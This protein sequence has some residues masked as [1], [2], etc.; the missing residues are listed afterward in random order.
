M[1]TEHVAFM[2]IERGGRQECAN[3]DSDAGTDVRVRVGTNA[4]ALPRDS[5]EGA[6]SSGLRR[7][8]APDFRRLMTLRAGLFP[9]VLGQLGPPSVL[10][11]F[12]RSGPSGCCRC[13]GG[14]TPAATRWYAPA[15]TPKTRPADVLTGTGRGRWENP[16]PDP[17]RRPMWAGAPA[18]DG[19]YAGRMYESKPWRRPRFRPV[20]LLQVIS[21]PPRTSPRRTVLRQAAPDADTSNADLQRARRSEASYRHTYAPDAEVSDRIGRWSGLDEWSTHEREAIELGVRATIIVP[22]ARRQPRPH[23]REID[24]TNPTWAEDHCP[25]RSTFVHHLAAGRTQRLD[26]HYV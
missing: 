14:S 2:L 8:V 17:D 7:S 4:R 22:C 13:S 1:L 26:I 25:P 10:W 5:D 6:S 15:V 12:R 9:V 24:F 16:G 11:A 20:Q 23:R 19:R 18:T 3:D 21:S